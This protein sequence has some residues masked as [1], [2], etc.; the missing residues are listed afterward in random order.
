MSL[1]TDFR[2]ALVAH[3]PLLA[4][5]AAASIAQNAVGQSAELPM[6]AFTVT[7]SLDIGLDNTVLAHGADFSVQCWGNTSAEADAVADAVA[8]AVQASGQVVTDRT[9]GFD[10]ELGLDATMLTVSWW[11]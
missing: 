8:A 1:E 9:S 4:L 11:P 3:A 10:P 5:V 7:H 2:A 6:V